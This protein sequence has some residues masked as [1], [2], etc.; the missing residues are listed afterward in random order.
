MKY[1]YAKLYGRKKV[2]KFDKMKEFVEFCE[3]NSVI[4]KE[5]GLRNGRTTLCV[6]DNDYKKFIGM[7][8][9]KFRI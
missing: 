4:I 7:I 8:P 3:D 5:I 1:F 9:D 2:F 6:G